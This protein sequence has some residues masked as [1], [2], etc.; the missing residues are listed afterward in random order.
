MRLR[1]LGTSSE[2]GDCPAAYETSNNTVAIQGK[3][4]LDPQALG[5][6]VNLGRGEALVEIPREMLKFIPKE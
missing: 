5:D 3:L 1:F 4:I 2:N 6:A